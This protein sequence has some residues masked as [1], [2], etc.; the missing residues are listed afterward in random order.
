MRFWGFGMYQHVHTWDH[1]Y[2]SCCLSAKSENILVL[3]M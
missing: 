3:C 2:E 1:M